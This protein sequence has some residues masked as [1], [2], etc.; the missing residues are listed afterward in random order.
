MTVAL[1]VAISLAIL[2]GLLGP[3]LAAWGFGSTDPGKV[4]LK[5]V[6]VLTLHSGKMTTGKIDFFHWTVPKYPNVCS[7]NTRIPSS[8]ALLYREQTAP[9]TLS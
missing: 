4:L 8:R 2:F 7:L 5:D 1:K 9:G 6:Q 3:S